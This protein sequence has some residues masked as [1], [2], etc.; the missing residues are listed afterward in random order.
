[1]NNLLTFEGL[2]ISLAETADR[3]KKIESL[4]D[5]IKSNKDEEKE[6]FTIPEASKYTK[7]P[8]ATLRIH[9]KEKKLNGM[10]PGKFWLF[11]KEDLD[12]YLQAFRTKKSEEDEAMMKY[13]E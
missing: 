11:Y 4:L 2:A 5:R 10:K 6:L 13:I 12:N 3:L 8:E 7:T 9:I 1:M